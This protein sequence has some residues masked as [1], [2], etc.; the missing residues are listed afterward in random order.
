MIQNKKNTLFVLLGL[1]PLFFWSYNYL[2]ADVWYDEAF[3]LKHYALVEW[4]QT[5]FYYPAPNNHIFYNITTQLLS[6]LTGFRSVSELLD[7]IYL[8][9]GFQLL[10]ALLSGGYL[11]KLLNRFFKGKGSHW[12]LLILYTTLPFLN[13]SLQLR[14]YGLSMLF[15]VMLV[16]HGWRY[17]KNTKSWEGLLVLIISTA[18]VYAIPSNV[19]FLGST[20]L[21]CLIGFVSTLPKYS[22]WLKNPFFKLGIWMTAGL[23]LALLLYAPIIDSVI[24]NPYSSREAPYFYV[25]GHIFINSIP[26]LLSARYLLIPLIIYGGWRYLKHTTSNETRGVFVLVALVLFPFLLAFVHQKL[27]Y[28]RVFLPITPIVAALI[29]LKMDYALEG[30]K[31]KKLKLLLNLAIAVYLIAVSVLVIDENSAKATENL[32]VNGVLS[33][34]LY[35]NYYLSKS[36][37]QDKVMLVLAELNPQGP[38]IEYNQL[39]LPSTHS[40]LKKY[41]IESIA[42]TSLEAIEEHM[43]DNKRSFLITSKPGEVIDSLKQIKN[44]TVSKKFSEFYFT[45][46]LLL[47]KA[48]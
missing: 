7:V 2:Q 23:L 11:Y 36:F 32:E 14:G 29:S 18:L 20:A 16:F 47:E 22:G 1:I 17:L 45:N 43:N 10:I 41:G 44:L 39:D 35:V 37:K 27:P 34:D 13:F 26:A 5:L 31:R 30:I 3:S 4:G 33:Q 42:L 6:R 19:Y 38:V 21:I 40:Y 8:F 25:S 24:N 28:Y 46:I 12:S 15:Y 48:D 9:R